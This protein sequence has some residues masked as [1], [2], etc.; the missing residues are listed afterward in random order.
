MLPKAVLFDVLNTLVDASTANDEY[1]GATEDYLRYKGLSGPR[2]SR[3]WDVP[4]N[5]IRFPAW[6]EVPAAMQR[7]VDAGVRCC[8]MSNV[9]M[10]VVITM[11][12][13]AGIP[14]EA[15]DVIPL[16]MY[17]VYK[18][19]RIAYMAALDHVGLIDDPS[20]CIMVTAN[21]TFGDIEGS[22]SV[23]MSQAFIDRANKQSGYHIKNLKDLADS[24]L[25]K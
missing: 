6:P 7:L 18:P 21:E 17:R 10:S 24:L 2:W 1:D 12:D 23:G 4:S 19:H 9:P 13:N 15:H 8:A 16:S 11:L 22:H 5:W 20:Q 3:M 25:G 14:I